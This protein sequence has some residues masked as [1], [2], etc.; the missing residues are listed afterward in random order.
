MPTDNDS[1]GLVRK[2]RM[3]R[4]VLQFVAPAKVFDAFC[5]LTGEMYRSVWKD[6]A[7]YVGCDY[8]WETNDTRRRFV[9]KNQRVMRAIDLTQYNVFDFDA[10]GTP[11]DQLWI[12]LHRRRWIPGEL[13]AVILT[14]GMGLQLNLKRNVPKAQ[15]DLLGIV[16]GKKLPPIG[17]SPHLS[18]TAIERWAKFARVKIEHK[19]FSRASG[20]GALVEY[21]AVVFRGCKYEACQVTLSPDRGGSA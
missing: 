10:Y 17:R 18:I 14:V 9:A 11:W 5:G 13:G 12:L 4:A 7:E 19:W 21:H 15:C 20:S 16:A 2:I 1:V 3:R 6:A 8:K